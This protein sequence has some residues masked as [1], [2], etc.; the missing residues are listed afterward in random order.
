MAL[1]DV[2]TTKVRT[3]E[4]W[5]PD[6]PWS[7]VDVAALIAD[8][9]RT[10]VPALDQIIVDVIDDHSRHRWLEVRGQ[11]WQVVEALAEADRMRLFG[12][13]TLIEAALQCLFGRFGMSEDYGSFFHNI[14]DWEGLIRDAVQST[15][16]IKM[17]LDDLTTL[18]IVRAARCKLK[19]GAERELRDV[20]RVLVEKVPEPM[21]AAQRGSL[22][23]LAELVDKATWHPSH[24]G[25]ILQAI[26]SLFARI[27]RPLAGSEISSRI[28]G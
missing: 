12:R 28:N 23:D 9:R 15:R 8:M 1:L 10:N 14:R 6:I 22:A 24:Y 18:D 21:S 5:S 16:A 17:K 27:G 2:F 3:L 7:D 20:A 13:A 19:L 26:E 4:D 11:A 25:E